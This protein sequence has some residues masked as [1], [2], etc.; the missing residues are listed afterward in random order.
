MDA[1][2]SASPSTFISRRHRANPPLVDDAIP[3]ALVAITKASTQALPDPDDQHVLNAALSAG[4]GVLLTFNLADFPASALPPSVQ[5]IHPDV[6]LA[7]CLEGQQKGVL[8]S[9]RELRADLKP[10]PFSPD[11]LLGA[12]LRAELP[13]FA[14]RLELFKNSL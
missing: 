4:A 1:E 14:A 11:D 2:P 5:A 10:P 7:A 8:E 3:G 9:L 6:F 12:M 13:A